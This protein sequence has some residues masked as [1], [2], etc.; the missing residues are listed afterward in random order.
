MPKK[1][2]AR[3]E[4]RILDAAY[5]LW[6]TG[7]EQSLT[8]RAVAKAA[9][10]TTPTVYQ[11]FQ[12]KRD[13]LEVM[14]GRALQELIDALASA[15][16]AEEVCARFLAFAIAHP[17]L[18]RLLTFDWAARLSRKEHKPS[19]ELITARLAERLGGS[20]EQH[21]ELA[22]SLGALVHGTATMLLANG[23]DK[24][25]SRDLQRICADSCEALIEHAEQSQRG[26]SKVARSRAEAR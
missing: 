6:K 26:T 17:N 5:E 14:R 16:S 19:F 4:G 12:D 20:P 7:G 11:R 25:V 9:A 13:L 1:P 3:L 22:M 8:M 24:K 18:Y 21:A 23:V 2:D 10:T 15:K